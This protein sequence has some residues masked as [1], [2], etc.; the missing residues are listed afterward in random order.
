MGS[1]ESVPESLV[2][3]GTI[4]KIKGRRIGADRSLPGSLEVTSWGDP[5]PETSHP[6]PDS[7]TA[8]QSNTVARR[9]Q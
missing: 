5:G 7:T 2:T 9:R 6:I 4:G 1:G 3:A 8:M